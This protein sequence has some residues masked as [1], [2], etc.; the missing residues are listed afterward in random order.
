[1]TAILFFAAQCAVLMTPYQTLIDSHIASILWPEYFKCRQVF[2]QELNKFWQPCKYTLLCVAL[3]FHRFITM[4]NG[5]IYLE[6]HSETSSYQFALIVCTCMHTMD[7]IFM[8][9][10]HNFAVFE[11][12][13]SFSACSATWW[14]LMRVSSDVT[15]SIYIS[16]FTIRQ[17][18]PC[19]VWIPL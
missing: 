19:S 3:F 12:L 10:T 17:W 2:I 15:F 11:E 16:F 5:R 4:K 14:T 8:K 1:M 18:V 13:V 7:T 6:H 9:C